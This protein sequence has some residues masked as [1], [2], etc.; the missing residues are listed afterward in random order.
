MVITPR[1]VLVG[2]LVSAGVLSAYGV[3][4][5][6]YET[7]PNRIVGHLLRLSQIP[8][9]LQ[10]A[11]CESWSVSDVLTTCTFDLD[12]KDF[13]TLLTGW[14]FKQRSATGGSY[15]FSGGP[16][17]GREFQ[18]ESEFGISDPPDF[19]NGGRVSLVADA[20]R[21]RFQVDYYEE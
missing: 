18:V 11:E 17:L 15:S 8:A 19:A 12:P 16:K 10:N 7:R 6:I 20:S 1:G 4:S 21:T 13:P 5:L 3:G 2:S 14:N 9:S